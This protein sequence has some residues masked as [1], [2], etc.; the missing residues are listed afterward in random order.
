ME[1]LPEMQQAM[2]EHFLAHAERA[3]QGLELLPGVKQ[4]LQALNVRSMGSLGVVAACSSLRAIHAGS[5]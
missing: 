5:F 4:L 1:K 3:G 2:V